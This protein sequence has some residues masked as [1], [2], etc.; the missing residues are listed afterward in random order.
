MSWRFSRRQFMGGLAVTG[1]AATI[2]GR[3]LAESAPS[4]SPTDASKSP[5]RVAVIT[6]EITQDFGRAL[7]IA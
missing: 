2:P 5:F 6:D 7:E 3:L 1:L 4:Y